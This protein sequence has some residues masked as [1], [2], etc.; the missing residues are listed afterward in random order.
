M[1]KTQYV[2]REQLET[3]IIIS[4]KKY[5]ESNYPVTPAECFTPK[6][7]EYIQLLINRYASKSQWRGYCLC[8]ESECLT[9]RGWMGIDDVTETDAILSYQDGRL[10]WSRIKSIYRSDYSGKL[11]HLTVQGLDAMVTPGHK[12]VTTEGLKPVEELREK[13]QLI[14][15]GNAT[16][17]PLN[18]IYDDAFVEL[19]GWVVTEGNY[20]YDKKRNYCRVSIYQNEGERADRIRTCLNS[21]EA[22]YS[23]GYQQNPSG[24]TNVTFHLTKNICEKILKVVPFKKPT[25]PFI[26]NITPAQRELLIDTM[27]TADGWISYGKYKNY[28]QCDKEHIDVFLALCTISGYQTS[29]KL[30]DPIGYGKK[31][32]YKVR[33]F[34][35][36]N[37]VESIDF[38]GAKN[39]NRI[40]GKPKSSYPN[41]PTIDYI[42]RV[43]CPET[44]YGS[45]IARR[46]GYIY[47]TGNSYIED[48]KSDALVTL[49]QNCFKYD[50]TRFNNPFGYL[51]QI[52]KYCFITFLE[53]EELMRDIKDSLWESIGMTPSYARQIKNEMLRDVVDQSNKGMKILKKD[54]DMIN[55]QIDLLSSII[56]KMK[57]IRLPD[58]DIDTAISE[59]L[60]I[61]ISAFTGDINA[62]TKLF[63]NPPYYKIETDV[64]IA[65]QKVNCL[66]LFDDITK[67]NTKRVI[68]DIENYTIITALCSIALTIRRDMLVKNVRDISGYNITSTRMPTADR[69]TTTDD[70]MPETTYE[71]A[72]KRRMHTTIKK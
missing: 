56:Y 40:I 54:A 36:K 12:F 61:E 14:L 20:Y 10:K 53:K 25:M 3:E 69:M 59:V 21:L 7:T 28:G 4:K 2:T 71:P 32:F 70:E 43:W 13:D 51:T 5:R 52:V 34:S 15:L 45:F 30:H 18:P 63:V 72:P 38:H 39:T 17:L 64:E 35:S 9:G 60:N 46:N 49:C 8:E 66:T 41:I 24:N 47:L 29:V 55:A 65:D 67:S 27:V 62:A 37:M 42:G 48:M 22:K 11:F 23:E 6:L 26:L 16:N 68:P 58:L 33:I 31:P 44:E 19:I 50:E 57:N 1:A